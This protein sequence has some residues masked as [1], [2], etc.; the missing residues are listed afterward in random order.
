MKKIV[1]SLSLIVSVATAETIATIKTSGV[2]IK[3]KLEVQAFDDGGV[4]CYI[5]MPKRAL[6]FEDQTDSSISCRQTGII[7]KSQ[8]VSQKSIFSAK[9]GLFVKSVHM[10]RIYDKKR[11]VLIYASYTSKLSGDNANNSV[12]VVVIK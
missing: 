5:S 12:S 9:K 11:N 6:S 1:L 3:D 10:D 8:L 2:F 4:T 7:N